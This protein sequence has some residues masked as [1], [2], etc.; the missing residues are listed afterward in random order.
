ME[1]PIENEYFNWLCAKVLTMPSTMYVELFKVLHNT[2]FA[3]FIP[4]DRNRAEDGDE[5]KLYFLNE[6]GWEREDDW[7]NQPCSVLEMLVALARNAAF[8]TD[9]SD[10]D[11]MGIFLAN[12]GLEQYRRLQRADIPAVEDILNTFIWRQYDPSGHGGLFPMRQP[13]HDQRKE[14]IWYQLSAYIEDQ[15]LG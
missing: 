10:R 2:P 15:G 3:W 7:L 13:I 1:E 4:G 9:I 12:L 8:Q 14:E 6:S 11:W 5:L